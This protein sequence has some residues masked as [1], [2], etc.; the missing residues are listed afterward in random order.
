MGTIARR[1]RMALAVLA[2]FGLCVSGPA[3]AIALPA[4][5]VAPLPDALA[6]PTAVEQLT[7]PVERL[8][9]PLAPVVET[10]PAVTEPDAGVPGPVTHAAPQPAAA[11]APP[12]TARIAWIG[13]AAPGSGMQTR[14]RPLAQPAAGTAAPSRQADT[15]GPQQGG[16]RRPAVVQAAAD[17]SLPLGIAAMVIA[18]LLVQARLDRHDPKLL[19]ASSH[20]GDALP[21]S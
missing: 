13:A 8:T 5:D 7:E 14:S 15:A 21:F 1:R 11:V 19:A 9:A 4:I 20:R 18:F 17:F 2:A 3:A 16:Q 6:D 12:S 10:L